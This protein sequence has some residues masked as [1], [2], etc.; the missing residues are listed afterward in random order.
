MN[1]FNVLLPFKVNVTAPKGS[2]NVFV[3]RSGASLKPMPNLKAPDSHEVTICRDWIKT[4]C[5][6]LK[7][8]KYNSSSYGLKHL[9]EEMANT[10]IPNGAFIQAAIEEGVPFDLDSELTCDGIRNVYFALSV[11]KNTRTILRTR[12]NTIV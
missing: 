2:Y 5:K 7:K 11:T 1:H 6:I 4:H 10:Y 9:V 8:V 12:H 3:Y